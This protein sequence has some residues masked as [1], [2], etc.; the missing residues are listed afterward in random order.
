MIRIM[1]YIEQI[2]RN[3][4][5]VYSENRYKNEQGPPKK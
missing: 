2:Q 5:R 4:N 1:I 3:K